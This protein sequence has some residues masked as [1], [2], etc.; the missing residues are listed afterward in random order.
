MSKFGAAKKCPRCGKSVYF[1][2]RALGP[3]GT[4]WHKSC[5]TC[6]DCNKRVD[7]TTLADHGGEAYCKNCYGKNFGPKGFGYGGGGAIMHTGDQA[8]TPVNAGGGTSSPVR[9]SS[10]ASSAP[11]AASS[12]SGG[13]APK[14]C[15][16][17][18]TPAAGA[19]FC[20]QCGNKLA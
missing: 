13:A 20:P 9:A 14:F 16:Q 3:G 2:E 1:A 17:C 6:K 18:G 10:P 8:K 5:L 4:D 19:K 15:P 7:S 11:A 12:T